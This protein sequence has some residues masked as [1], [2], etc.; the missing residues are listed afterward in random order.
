MKETALGC[1]ALFEKNIWSLRYFCGAGRDRV[2][3]SRESSVKE[4]LDM[5]PSIPKGTTHLR[6]YYLCAII[7]VK[8]SR[9]NEMRM[10]QRVPKTCGTTDW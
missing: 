1:S 8:D 6:T 7:S 10:T 2:V 3:N 5:R 4:G 9:W